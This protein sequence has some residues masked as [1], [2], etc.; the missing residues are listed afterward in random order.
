MKLLEIIQ[1]YLYHLGPIPSD[2][3]A[4]QSSKVSQ[5]QHTE[6]PVNLTLIFMSLQEEAGEPGDSPHIREENMQTAHRKRPSYVL[7]EAKLLCRTEEGC[8]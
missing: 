7:K 6:S 8:S 2:M 1:C 4:G 5:G 3:C